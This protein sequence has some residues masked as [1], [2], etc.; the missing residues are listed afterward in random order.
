LSEH[1]R[2]AEEQLLKGAEAKDANGSLPSVAEVI[3]ARKIRKTGDRP[4]IFVTVG[5]A[6]SPKAVVR[7]KVKRRVRAIASAALKKKS[8]ESLVLSTKKG[9]AEKSFKEL[10]NETLRA[11]QKVV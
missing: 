5:K 3:T 4:R 1:E 7:N 8:G 2:R 6:V 11:L 9:V 10:E